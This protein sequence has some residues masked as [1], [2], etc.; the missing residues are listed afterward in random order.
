MTVVT[1]SWVVAGDDGSG[2]EAGLWL[3]EGIALVTGIDTPTEVS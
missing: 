3:G 2:G 1:T